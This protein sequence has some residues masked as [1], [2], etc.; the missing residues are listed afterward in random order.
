V[1]VAFAY[2]AVFADGSRDKSLEWAINCNI[3]IFTLCRIVV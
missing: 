2:F 1:G 3:V